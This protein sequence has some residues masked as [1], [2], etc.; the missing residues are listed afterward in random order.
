MTLFDS[1]GRRNMLVW[2]A[3]LQAVFLFAM[4]GIGLKKNPTSA[5]AHGLVATVMLFNFFFSSTWAPIAYVIGSEIGTGALREKTMS[6]TSTVN[7]VAAWLVAF[8]VPYLLDDIGANIG[9]IFGG[10]SII[11]T[12]YAY[13]RVPEISGRSL[14]ELDELF[15][16]RVPARQFASAETHGA[17]HRIAE[18]ENIG[19]RRGARTAVSEEQLLDVEGVRVDEDKAGQNFVE[20]TK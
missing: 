4:A 5:D 20:R 17:A 12:F 1:V 3:V 9:W 16:R 8:T 6:F 2:G 7:V 10:F 11:A 13:F 15:E 18:L 19:A 14:E